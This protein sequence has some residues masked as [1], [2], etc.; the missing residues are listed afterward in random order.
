MGKNEERKEK[1]VSFHP[2]SR[3][4]PSCKLAYC[5]VPQA[6]ASVLQTPESP[7]RNFKSYVEAELVGNKPPSSETTA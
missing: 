3:M 1:S 4:P 5:L 6:H 2:F 7:H